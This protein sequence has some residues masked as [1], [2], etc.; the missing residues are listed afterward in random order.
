MNCFR[1]LAASFVIALSIGCGNS[2]SKSESQAPTFSLAWS[3]YPSWSVFGVADERGIIN[4]K[5]GEQSDLEKKWN[6]DIELKGVDYDA[7]ITLYG[8][9][10]VDAACLTNMDSLAPAIGRPSVAVLP[11][12]T[13]AGADALIAV[14][15]GEVTPD[16]KNQVVST[17]LAA[18]PTY[19]LEKSVSQYAF[20]RNLELMGLNPKEYQFK[21]MDPATAAQAIQTG[22]E[23]I[24]AIMV[25][26]PFVLQTLRTRQNSKVLFD[27]SAIPE[28]I[29]DMVVVG[30]DSLKRE[31]GDRFACAVIEAYYEVN[32]LL[33]STDV[34][35]N[36]NKVADDTLVALGSKFSN[37]GL[38]DMKLVV[39]QTRFYSTP[40]AALKIFGDQKFQQTTMPHIVEFCVKHDIVP[41]AVSIGFNNTNAQLDFD[42]SYIQ[43]VAGSK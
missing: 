35:S 26:N 38:E 19:G 6:V 15:V 40:D 23:N 1:L 14:D 16:N 28:E 22:Q 11:T 17:F 20:E 9:S 39:Q 12:S 42:T 24:S 29:I 8:S 18:K 3:E 36:G 7:C 25:W 13:S 31:G 37:L 2:G 4:G 5:K 10:T 34:D 27:S 43:R 30:R 32:R 33:A 41:E 21:N